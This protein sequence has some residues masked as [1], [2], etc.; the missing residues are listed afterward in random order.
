MFYQKR[1]IVRRKFVRKARLAGD[2]TVSELSVTWRPIASLRGPLEISRKEPTPQPLTSHRVSIPHAQNLRKEDPVLCVLIE[3]SDIGFCKGFQDSLLP[4][5]GWFRLACIID[6]IQTA[7]MK[8][9]VRT[10]FPLVW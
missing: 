2:F 6:Q 10:C 8:P 9:H 4:T 5:D 1:K 3:V 7:E